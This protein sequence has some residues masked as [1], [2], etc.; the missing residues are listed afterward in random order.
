MQWDVYIYLKS[1]NDV[2]FRGCGHCKQKHKLAHRFDPTTIIFF[3]N[4]GFMAMLSLTNT[5][6]SLNKHEGP[7]FFRVWESGEI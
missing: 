6:F 3:L 4:H 1:I 2:K 7:I 5:R